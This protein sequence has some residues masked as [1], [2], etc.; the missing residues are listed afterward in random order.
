LKAQFDETDFQ[1][2]RLK[3]LKEVSADLLVLRKAVGALI[4]LIDIACTKP[5]ASGQGI[6]FADLAN[7][8]LRFK[9]SEY[10]LTIA[11]RDLQ[12]IVFGKE[13]LDLPQLLEIKSSVD[14]RC[15][16]INASLQMVVLTGA[17]SS[18]SG[19]NPRRE[20]IAEISA[21]LTN[22]YVID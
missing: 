8:Y 5:I 17:A 9:S 15:H 4:D 1:K 19:P 10:D 6:T 18:I 21:F 7:F 13:R 14:T 20:Y 2:V 16:I 11:L 12:I 22:R 3:L